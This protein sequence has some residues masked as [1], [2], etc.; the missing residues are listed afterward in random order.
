MGGLDAAAAVAESR[1][2]CSDGLLLLA[3][4]AVWR[5]GMD[6]DVD[7]ARVVPVDMMTVCCGCGRSCALVSTI[8][9]LCPLEYVEWPVW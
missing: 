4:L 8:S 5:D 2:I 1:V 6:E 7:A 9:Q 3:M